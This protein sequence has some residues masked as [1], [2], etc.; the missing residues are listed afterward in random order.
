MG[1][2]SR[3]A[4]GPG[5]SGKLK[6]SGNFV[7]FEKSQGKVSEFRESQKSQGILTR[8]WEKSA[9]FTCVKRISPKFIQDSFKW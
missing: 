4:S 9:N 2:F 5:I 3:V 7:A 8:N 6:K 1:N